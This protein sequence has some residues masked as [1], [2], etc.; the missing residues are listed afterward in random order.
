M[1]KLKLN[2]SP[3]LGEVLTKDELKHVFGGSGVGSGS[4]SSSGTLEN[5]GCSG[6]KENDSCCY[7][8]DGTK[9]DGHCKYL[10]FSGLQCWGG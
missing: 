8:K 3:N 1:K 4:G 6:K 7:Y 10:P 2:L 5:C 9:Y